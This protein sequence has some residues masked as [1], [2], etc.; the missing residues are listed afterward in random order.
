MVK[1]TLLVEQHL[2]LDPTLKRQ[3]AEARNKIMARL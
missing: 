3:L 2:D 1:Y